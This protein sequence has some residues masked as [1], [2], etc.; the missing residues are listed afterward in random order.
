MSKVEYIKK[1]TGG[2][3]ACTETGHCYVQ[4]AHDGWWV[5]TV[6]AE[7]ALSV[8]M[9]QGPHRT[10]A[11]AVLA[12]QEA[13]R[14]E[15]RRAYERRV[16]MLCRFLERWDGLS[17]DSAEDRATLAHALARDGAIHPDWEC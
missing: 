12:W 1:K 11:A 7:G 6:D 14:V 4:Q 16:V 9:P 3:I 5:Q 17:L 15:G 13:R 10:R 8:D 2:Y